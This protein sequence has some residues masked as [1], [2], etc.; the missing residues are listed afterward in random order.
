M[1]YYILY[2][3]LWSI[4]SH[5]YM[6]NKRFYIKKLYVVGS[7]IDLILK[8]YKE[9]YLTKNLKWRLSYKNLT[10]FNVRKLFRT[11]HK[12]RHGDLFSDLRKN[13]IL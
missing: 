1:E 10:N 11:V 3:I 4:I 6:G 5:R 8:S 9:K 2:K 13:Y 7:P 12:H